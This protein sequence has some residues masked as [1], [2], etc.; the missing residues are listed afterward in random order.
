M[1]TGDQL[2]CLEP[3]VMK[4]GFCLL[5]VADCWRYSRSSSMYGRR[6]FI[7]RSAPLLESSMILRLDWMPGRALC[8]ALRLEWLENHRRCDK[9]R[10][11]KDDRANEE[12]EQLHRYLHN[13][14]EEQT[15]PALHNRAAGEVSLHLALITSKIGQSKK[16]AANQSAPQVVAIGPVQMQ[17]NDIQPASSAGKMQGIPE[18][19]RRRKRVNHQD[20]ADD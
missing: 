2:Q 8:G 3:A 13:S 5:E 17:I 6:Q 11:H 10:E 20:Q 7:S 1:E 9:Q 14:V 15:Q 18:R 16:C 4:F 12:N 19:D